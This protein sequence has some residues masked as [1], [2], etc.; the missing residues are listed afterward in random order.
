MYRYMLKKKAGFPLLLVLLIV[1]EVCGNL[2]SL[3]MSS[4]VDSAG[5]SAEELTATFWCSIVFV[6]VCV[7]LDASYRYIRTWILTDARY[8][9]KKDLFTSIMN[10]SVPDFDAESSAEYIN[11]LSNNVNLFES[12]YFGNFISLMESLVSFVSAAAICIAIQPLM[13]ALMLL[14]ALVTTGVGRLTAPPLKKSM[15]RQMECSEAYTGEIKDDFGAFRLVRSYGVLPHILNKHDRKNFEAEH[16]RRQ[17]ANC[18]ILCSGTG[19]FVG[20]L[21]TVLVMAMAAYFSLKGMFSAGMII[22]F[23]HLIGHIVSPITSIPSIAAD[24]HAAKPLIKRFSALLEQK[25]EIGTKPLSDFRHAVSIEHLSFCYEEG[26]EILCNLSCRF[27]AGKRYAVTGRSGCGKSTLLSL[28][29]GYY[30]DYSGSVR[31]DD[32]ELREIRKDSLGVLTGTVSQDTF[33]FQDTIRNNISLYDDTY[34][35]HEI[36]EALRQAGL[37]ALVD[38]LPEGLSTVIDENGKNFSGGEKQRLSL[39][40]ALLRKSKI[41]LLDEFTANLD[42]KTAQEIEEQ[43]LERKDCL[44]I[45]VTHH[46]DPDTMERYDGILNLEQRPLLSAP[47][48][49]Q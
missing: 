29:L 28:L 43:L 39:A 47:V 23:G 21:S 33:L 10:R 34:T 38:S 15:K 16:S 2:F 14:L 12:V 17:S 36:E 27:E 5:K 26:R 25:E 18:H 3:V 32:T 35:T 30:P 4:L 44:I 49:V 31:I 45:A 7:L 8:R 22:A 9:L 6:T 46:L 19:Q 20:L 1:S 48:I 37:K 40:R 41:L 24:F 11:E 42:K 13:L